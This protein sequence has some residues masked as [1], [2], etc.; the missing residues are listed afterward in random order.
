M[1]TGESFVLPDLLRRRADEDPRGTALVVHGGETL[2]YEAWDR[3]SEAVARSL[4]GRGVGRGDRVAILFDNSRWT[5]YAVAYLGVLKAAAVAVPLSPR[6][7][8]A[9]LSG[10]LAHCDPS[11]VVGP[12]DL[13][14]ALPL[15]PWWV[16][17][18]ADLDDGNGRQPNGDLRD[19][20]DPEDL[21]EI[22][23]TSGTTGTPKG[24]ACSHANLM[25]HE[26]PPDAGDAPSPLITFL[27]AFPIGTNAGQEVLRMPLRRAGRVAVVLPAFDPEELCAAV[28][29]HR[30]TRLQLVPAMAQVL[31]D[32]GAPQGHDLSSIER[33]TLSSAAVSASLLSRLADALPGATLCNAYALTESGTARTLLVDAGSRPR[34]VGRPVG[35]TEVR[36][37][38][39]DGGDVPLGAMGEIWLR[40]PG[41]PT[42]EYYQDPEATA[43]AFTP[44]GWLRTGDL[45]HL[46]DEG[47]LYLDDR[48]KDLVISGG[49]NISPSEVENVLL[50]HDAVAD[51]AVFG[52]P[53]SVLGEDLAAAV[54]LRTPASV[55]ELQAFVR[56]KLAEHKTP[57]SVVVVDELPRNASGKVLK[58]ELPA[59]LVTSA[60]SEPASDVG[61]S[62]EP[63]DAASITPVEAAVLSIWQE[64]LG[65]SDLGV[66]DDF[67]ELGGHSLA[68][69]QIAARVQETF[70]LELPVTVV[71]EHPTVSELAEV[72]EV[73][74]RPVAGR[75]QR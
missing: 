74:R 37:V 38:D 72:V 61:A 65:Q 41:A 56:G 49:I 3:R 58:R 46:D 25:F 9:E 71:F 17:S 42:R 60:S 23:Y 29:E 14:A 5:D 66:H 45:G 30:V 47:F 35:E 10:I 70:S 16:A 51:V 50:S 12:P 39:G 54:V 32:S 11:V 26:L 67:F 40:R 36:V 19:S 18:V 59:L 15:G 73:S 44:E 27:H 64:A 22:I 69:V 52:I 57:H 68:A 33:L 28:A 53:H 55:R 48:K 62:L 7:S 1:T 31:L 34:S 63:A 2:D 75:R 21:A 43:A 24:V 6:F 13:A 4:A 20:P 8:E